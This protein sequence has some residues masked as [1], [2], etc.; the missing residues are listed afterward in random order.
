MHSPHTPIAHKVSGTQ[1]HDTTDWSIELLRGGAALLVVLA[2]YRDMLGLEYWA[3]NFTFTGVDLFFV[4]SG[5]V[6]AP[7]L[8]GRRLDPIPFYIRRFFRLYPL[9]IVAV[10]LYA[11]LHLHQNSGNAGHTLTLILKHALFLH[12]T[13]D[14]ATAFSLNPA[15]WSL[16]P[17]VEFYLVL[18]LLCLLGGHPGRALSIAA[19]A[20]ILHLAL[21]AAS[22]STAQPAAT[23]TTTLPAL[24]LVHLPGLLVE[25]MLGTLAWQLNRRLRTDAQRLALILGG[26]LAWLALAALFHHHHDQAPHL[27]ALLHGN[28]GLLAALTFLPM[29][30]G[31]A[32]AGDRFQPV[33]RAFGRNLGRLSYGTYLFHNATPRLLDRMLDIPS[34]PMLALC[35]LLLT[36][37]LAHILNLLV[38]EPARNRGRRLAAR[39]ARPSSP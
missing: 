34:R 19:C 17:E 3:V 11:A 26:F 29:V 32:G 20:L 28:V 23:H 35:A 16:P 27:Q 7:Y 15:F 2:H 18:P 33:L 1:P 5:F 30:A 24:L 8:H 38:E 25:F 21:A 9:Y 22:F 31:L 10:L 37:L 6:F 14:I 4:L 13:Q 36:L 39:R 12:T